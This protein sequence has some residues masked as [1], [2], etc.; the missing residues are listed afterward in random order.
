MTATEEQVR[1]GSALEADQR[2]SDE[3]DQATQEAGFFWQMHNP[4]ATDRLIQ[5]HSEFIVIGNALALLAHADD[6]TKQVATGCETVRLPSSAF[7]R[8]GNS[9]LSEAGTEEDVQAR[10]RTMHNLIQARVRIADEIRSALERG[11]Q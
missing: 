7:A 8:A 3:I 10:E 5:L 1:I 9:V 11:D 2:L 6:R 4:D